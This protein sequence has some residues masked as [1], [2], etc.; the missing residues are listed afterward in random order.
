M[1]DDLASIRI[2]LDTTEV[3]ELLSAAEYA[4]ESGAMT[5]EEAAETLASFIKIVID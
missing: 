1:P 2:R 3:Q 4:I 5:M